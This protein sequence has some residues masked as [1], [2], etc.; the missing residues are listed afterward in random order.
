MG[1]CPITEELGGEFTKEILV[2]LF[3]QLPNLTSIN[4]AGEWDPELLEEVQIT[5]REREG[6]RAAERSFLTSPREQ[7][8]IN[9]E[10]GAASEVGE[11]QIQ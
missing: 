1:G 4:D 6:A 7:P 10:D 8:D 3:G 11:A 5:A 2:I 9:F